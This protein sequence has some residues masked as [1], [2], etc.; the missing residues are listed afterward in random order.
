MRDM[1]FGIGIDTGS[2]M[3][4]C[5]HC[6]MVVPWSTT[7]ILISEVSLRFD[8]D[9]RPHAAERSPSACG[10]IQI[11]ACSLGCLAPL[12]AVASGRSLTPNGGDD[13]YYERKRG[14]RL[15]HAS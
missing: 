2:K 9:N 5:D 11:V 8:L 7:L 12:V 13:D 14:R 1:F 3:V 6:S 10:L 4:S 15:D